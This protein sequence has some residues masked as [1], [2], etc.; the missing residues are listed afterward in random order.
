[1]NTF[2]FVPVHKKEKTHACIHTRLHA[3]VYTYHDVHGCMYVHMYVCM[4]DV[5]KCAFILR[6]NNAKGMGVSPTAILF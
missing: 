4:H 5:W 6:N 2:T 1:M 3:S